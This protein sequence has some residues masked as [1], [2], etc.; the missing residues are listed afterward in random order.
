MHLHAKGVEGS[1]AGDLDAVH[2]QPAIVAGVTAQYLVDFGAEAPLRN[3]LIKG[4]CAL[5]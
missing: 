5:R 4:K 2:G 1:Q 3:S